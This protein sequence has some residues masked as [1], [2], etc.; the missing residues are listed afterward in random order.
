MTHIVNS[1]DEYKDYTERFKGSCF[2]RG[3]AKSEWIIEPSI[4]RTK[5]TLQDEQNII[6]KNACNI[7]D[8]SHK[9]FPKSL[10]T[11]FWVQHNNSGTRICDLT[12][13]P[14]SA[15]Y[16]AVCEEEEEDGAIFVI[17]RKSAINGDSVEMQIFDKVLSGEHNLF[18]LQREVGDSLNVQEILTQNYIINPKDMI[19]NNARSIRQGGTG[20]I[21]GFGCKDNKLSLIGNPNGCN[22]SIAKII[23]PKHEKLNIKERLKKEG[24]TKEKLYLL[25][26]NYLFDDVTIIKEDISVEMFPDITNKTKNFYCLRG[27]Y[28][29]STRYFDKIALEAKIDELHKRLFSQ[30]GN[31]ARIYSYF[32][33]D[34]ND[35]IR[36]NFICKY[37]WYKNSGHKLEWSDERNYEFRRFMSVN[38][39]VSKDTAI[40][41]ACNIVKH[42]NIIYT[43]IKS[44]ISITNYD[45]DKLFHVAESFSE[46]MQEI[47]RKDIP[48]GDS[49]IQH[50]IETAEGFRIDVYNLICD[51]TNK[52]SRTRTEANLRA[53]MTLDCKQCDE[54]YKKFT[55][56]IKQS[57]ISVI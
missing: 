15:L 40:N 50:I 52:Q 16:F 44:H 45:I 6:N 51:L 21:F 5:C 12:T 41:E 25:P 48:S 57:G 36:A 11:L 10:A 27:W 35:R 2:F 43:A 19:I 26:E 17:D 22:F 49:E 32:Y 31:N 9:H 38:S 23:I 34:E 3:Q 18:E 24:Y 1:F 30:Y 28:K 53:L 54:S 39:E 14:F 13:N 29:I 42:S 33:F 56:S 55:A 20:I 47:M 7:N 4:I 46:D 37:M 8:Y